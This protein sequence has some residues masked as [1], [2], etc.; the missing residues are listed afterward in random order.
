MPV[1]VVPPPYRGPT[2]GEGEIRVGAA[3]VRGCIEAVEARHPGFLAQVLDGHGRVHR[4]VNLF[5]NGDEIERER[6]DR[7]LAAEDRL[8]ILAAIAGG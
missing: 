2:A 6:L 8:E 1:V 5:V 7:P 3:T 4:F